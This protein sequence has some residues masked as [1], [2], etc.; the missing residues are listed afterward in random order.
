MSNSSYP[1]FRPFRAC[2]SI[3]I[4]PTSRLLG[5]GAVGG[6]GQGAVVVSTG[7]WMLSVERVHVLRR[8]KGALQWRVGGCVLDVEKVGA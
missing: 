3:V 8:D 7:G 2:S 4:E 5:V 1:V 6:E